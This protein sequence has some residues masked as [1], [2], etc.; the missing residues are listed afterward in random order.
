MIQAFT[1]AG[2]H[3]ETPHFDGLVIPDGGNTM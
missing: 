3:V 2:P 1:I